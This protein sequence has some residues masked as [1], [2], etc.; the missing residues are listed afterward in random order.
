MRIK[1]Y[2]AV[3]LLFFQ[4]LINSQTTYIWTG[5][6]NSSFSTAGNWNPVRQVSRSTDRLIFN[7]GI[8]NVVTNV[9]QVTFAQLIITGNTQLTLTP[10][11]GNS[12]I[13]YIQSLT[14]NN[15]GE[16]GNNQEYASLKYNEYYTGEAHKDI[17]TLKYEEY[18]TPT[19]IKKID[20]ADIKYSEYNY[21][22]SNGMGDLK[23]GENSNSPF[24]NN[25]YIENGS[26]LKI[27]ANDPSLSIYLKSNT[28]AEIYGTLIMEGTIQNSINSEDPYSLYF[29][30]GSKIVQNCPGNLFNT[31]G[32]V[33]AVVFE[34]GSLLEVNNISALNPFAL[35]APN[36]KVVF[37][38]GSN[39][40]LNSANSNALRLS[41]RKYANLEIN[42]NI[43]LNEIITTDC[44]IGNFTIKPGASITIN[45]LNNSATTPGIHI[46]GNLL[47][48]GELKFPENTN[49]NLD[50]YFDGNKLQNISGNG[51]PDLNSGLKN[52]FISNDIT[53]NRDF[54]MRCNV[55]HTGGN[56]NC[57][58]HTLTIYGSFISASI[59]PPG[60]IIQNESSHAE[61]GNGVLTHYKENNRKD[62]SETSAIESVGNINK[63]SLEFALNQN[64]PN[65]FN[66]STTIEFSLPES[67]HV[68][69]SVFDISGK[70]ISVISDKMYQP[71]TYKIEYNANKLSSGI[72]FY[73]I[74]INYGKNFFKDSKKMILTK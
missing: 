70:E 4:S 47:L 29:M 19:E 42:S 50:L 48:N 9:N 2:L 71:G 21:G 34:S 56:I 7:N 10:G 8:N 26:V 41:G 43:I 55:L 3:L 18:S 52:I 38:E 24:D 72:Y 6:I 15:S 5:G 39:F 20:Q 27:T 35:Q 60:V 63:V 1:Y 51:N 11:T 46:H 25:I 32:A 17:A 49:K 69:L 73:K 61:F 33:N 53:F 68:S 28:R 37:E 64:Y 54:E 13:I 30:N 57:S 23:T 45:N 67:G 59:L 36:S 58:E 66:P 40:K 62:L 12:R 16:N 22:P 31:N 14:D 74:L 65:P 44:I